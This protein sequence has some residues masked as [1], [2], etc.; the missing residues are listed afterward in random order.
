M[1]IFCSVRPLTLFFQCQKLDRPAPNSRQ[2]FDTMKIAPPHDREISFSFQRH[3][4]LNSLISNCQCTY[5]SIVRALT[6]SIF[7]FSCSCGRS[8]KKTLFSERSLT[9]RTMKTSSRLLCMPFHNAVMVLCR[10][11]GDR[12]H[13]LF[14]PR[15]SPLYAPLLGKAGRR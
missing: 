13:A 12:H 4:L 10:R 14:L 5:F 9:M 3:W 2:F 6:I 8:Y 15:T 11:Q 1:R 7:C